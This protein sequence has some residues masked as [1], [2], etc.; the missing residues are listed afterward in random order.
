MAMEESIGDIKLLCGPVTRGSNGKHSVNCSGFDHRQEGFAEVDA[1][2]L[3]KAMN[4]PPGLVSFEGPIRIEFV[5][6]YTFASDDVGTGWTINKTPSSI[7]LKCIKL[8]SHGSFLVRI[9]ESC[10]C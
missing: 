6:K 3:S 1:R 10:T 9:F 7:T 4:D 8:K 2:T 5:V